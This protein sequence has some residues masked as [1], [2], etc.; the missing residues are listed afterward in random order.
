MA[1]EEY[2][3]NFDLLALLRFSD[4]EIRRIVAKNPSLTVREYYTVLSKFSNEAP[5]VTEALTKIINLKAGGEDFRILKDIKSI[6]AYIGCNKFTA[7]F[8]DII[9]SGRANSMKFASACAKRIIDDFKTFHTNLLNTVKGQKTIASTDGLLNDNNV[10]QFGP[11][12][13]KEVINFL[14]RE[15]AARKLRILVIDD[16]PMLIKTVSSILNR[17][18]QVYGMTEPKNLENFLQQITPELFLLDYKMP[19]LSGFDLIPIIRKF[20]EHKNTPIIFLTS[21]GTPEHVSAAF[22]LGACDFVVK[23]FQGNI[24]REKIDRHISRKIQY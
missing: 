4:L 5:K 20:E 7:S 23:P 13:F 2:I 18:Y 10:A 12:S 22:A 14:D 8:D 21:M 16:S 11:R 17:D 1:G 9:D 19:D 3:L 24:L 15:Q 6:L